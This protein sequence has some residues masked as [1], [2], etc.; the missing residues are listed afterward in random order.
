VLI[1]DEQ[2]ADGLL[3]AFFHAIKDKD[4]VANNDPSKR[5]E[6]WSNY[7]GTANMS[8]DVLQQIEGLHQNIASTIPLPPVS[9]YPPTRIFQLHT[10]PTSPTRP[11]SLIFSWP[12]PRRP[13][14]SPSSS[15]SPSPVLPSFDGSY[16]AREYTN[17]MKGVDM[18]P[19][20]LATISPGE[21][22]TSCTTRFG[23]KHGINSEGVYRHVASVFIPYGNLIFACFQ[24]IRQVDL[25][26]RFVTQAMVTSGQSQ[27]Y[28]P[29]QGSGEQSQVNVAHGMITPGPSYPLDLHQRPHEETPQQL[30][31]TPPVLW[32]T[33]PIIAQPPPVNY[34]ESLPL[35]TPY[36]TPYPQSS[37]YPQPSPYPLSHQHHHHSPHASQLITP[38]SAYGRG[39]SPNPQI[40]P[41]PPPYPTPMEKPYDTDIYNPHSP[42]QASGKGGL[43]PVIPPPIGVEKCRICGILESPEWRRS[44]TGI[45]DLCN[46]WVLANAGDRTADSSLGVVCDWLDRLRRGKGDIN[47]GR[48]RIG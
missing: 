31:P 30:Q 36:T 5:N 39:S 45:K 3:L 7:C 38:Y 19:A 16:N 28:Q 4:P 8:E 11:G 47:L 15:T 29:G 2:I 48:R 24:T 26:R 10:T 25:G 18:D 33:P 44:E 23:A 20:Q 42:D 46:A 6:E 13:K 40:I 37:T 41:Q 32:P 43:R 22:R 12:P 14:S 21:T 17:L 1:R 27:G 34:S 35:V 9:R